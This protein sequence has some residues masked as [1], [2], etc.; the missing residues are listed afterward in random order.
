MWLAKADI[1]MGRTGVEAEV[2]ETDAGSEGI[3]DGLDSNIE[4]GDVP[5][6]RAST[7]RIRSR[8]ASEALTKG[9]DLD[10]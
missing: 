4:M 2:T 6:E 7:L 5:H 8:A 1:L 9:Q 3:A 10:S